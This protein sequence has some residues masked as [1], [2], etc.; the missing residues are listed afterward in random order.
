MSVKRSVRIRVLERDGF[1]CRYCGRQAPQVV[2]EI[3]HV[4]PRSQG[5]RDSFDNLVTACFDCNR[6][7]KNRLIA[8]LQLRERRIGIAPHA[9][10]YWR[11]HGVFCGDCGWCGTEMWEEVGGSPKPKACDHCG[12]EFHWIDCLWEHKVEVGAA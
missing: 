9:P 6:G 8:P 5:G 3:D 10:Q 1:K 12:V 7:K 4:L 2:L 11:E